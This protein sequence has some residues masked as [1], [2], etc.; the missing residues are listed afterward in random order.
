MTLLT[1]SVSWLILTCLILGLTG[2]ATQQSPVT[3]TTLN[4]NFSFLYSIQISQKKKI[5]FSG[6]LA[7]RGKGK[8]LSYA[9]LDPTGITLLSATITEDA[10]SS[11]KYMAAKLGESP[12]PELL[13][14]SLY[15]IFFSQSSQMKCKQGLFSFSVESKTEQEKMR[16]CRAGPFPWWSVHGSP[17]SESVLYSQPWLGVK[18]KLV[19]I[20]DANN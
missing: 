7:T 1:K 2:C 19:R 16:A 8:S 3:D 6:I 4:Q 18:I 10:R 13:T 14:S 5:R 11:T 17:V 12:L 20:T 15:R 9:L